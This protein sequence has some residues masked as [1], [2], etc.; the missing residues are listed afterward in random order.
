MRAEASAREAIKG[1]SQKAFVE[2]M[3]KERIQ[4]ENMQK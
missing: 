4:K 2:R 1:K 3:E